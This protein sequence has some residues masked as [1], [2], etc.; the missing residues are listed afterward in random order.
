VKREHP[1]RIAKRMNWGRRTSE[2]NL[3]QVMEQLPVTRK[4]REKGKRL[5]S[6]LLGIM[7]QQAVG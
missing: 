2:I 6:I 4:E 7:N 3:T 1:N 5:E